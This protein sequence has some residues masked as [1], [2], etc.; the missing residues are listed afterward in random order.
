MKKISIMI[1]VLALVLVGL[2]GYSSLQAQMTTT[3]TPT[4]GVVN[5]AQ[6]LMQCQ[7]KLDRERSVRAQAQQVSENLSQLSAEITSLQT[8]LEQAL[9]PGTDAY[10]EALQNYFD[11]RALAEAYR[12]GQQEAMSQDAEVWMFDIYSRLQEEVTRLARQRGLRLVLNLDDLPIQPGD[13]ESVIMGRN[14]L[15]S[16]PTIDLTAQVLENMDAAYAAAQLGQ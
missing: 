10:R 6:V 1:V 15:Y 13:M 4:I 8:E 11:R 7:E 5:V 12:Q 2:Y 16:T 14:V 3:D 9:E